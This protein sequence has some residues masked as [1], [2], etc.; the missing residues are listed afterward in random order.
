MGQRPPEAN[1]VGEADGV[2]VAPLRH[3]LH[4]SD[5]ARALARRAVGLAVRARAEDGVD[6]V[7]V[8][9]LARV[10][11]PEAVLEVEGAR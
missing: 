2:L 6:D 1:L 8:P 10:V 9:E 4:R 5:E 11:P 7:A 3:H